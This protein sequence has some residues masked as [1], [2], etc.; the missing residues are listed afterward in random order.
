MGLQ[1]SNV[2]G[3]TLRLCGY[4]ITNNY[5]L[6]RP[7]LMGGGDKKASKSEQHI[8]LKSMNWDIFHKHKKKRM[9]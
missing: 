3:N 5:A 9:R 1:P 6:H 8:E 7:F 2:D 4:Q